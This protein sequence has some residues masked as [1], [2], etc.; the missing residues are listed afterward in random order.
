MARQKYDMS[1]K[2]LLNTQGKGA[3]L[4]G[5][6]KDVDRIEPLPPEIVQTRK[7]PDGL[8]RVF[9]RRDA[10]PHMCLIEVATRAEKR[11]P[12]QA[13]SDLTMAYNALGTFRSY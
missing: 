6:L 10:K 1:S 5:G 9:L 8:L 2:W 4:V 7:Y 3:L 12:K 13:L 11:A